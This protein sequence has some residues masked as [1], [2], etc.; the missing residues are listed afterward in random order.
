[1]MTALAADA[2]THEGV[3]AS[4]RW[5]A[6]GTSAHLLTTRG[7]ALWPARA[8]VEQELAAI[9]LAASR[10]RTDS[11]LSRL[12]AA[13]GGWVP[14]SPL[15]S[16][17]LR[18]ALD[19][20][21]WTGGMVD[22]TVGRSLLDIGYTQTYRLVPREGPAISVALRPA[23][24]WQNLELDETAG[25]ARLTDGILLD[26][27]ATAKGLA[28]DL[29]AAAAAAAC[30][31]GVLVNLGGDVSVA[32]EVPPGGWPVLVTDDSTT[33]PDDAAALTATGEGQTIALHA[34]GLATSGTRARRW[35]RGGSELHHIV[36]PRSGRPTDGPWR[37]VSVAAATCVMANAASTATMVL[38]QG[39][40]SW[41]QQ[42][43]LAARLVGTDGGVTTTQGW[44]R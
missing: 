38:G 25:C 7:E 2:A 16:Q 44:P 15:F 18:V 8:A 13:R 12:N 14:V 5:T 10:F 4:A 31:A 42:K 21:T 40:L 28:S 24:G 17:A 20:A 35:R 32:G 39:G 9:D 6:L 27:G 36:D 19:A 22:P 3:F 33:S 41:L 37:T 11:E 1:M 34:G 23:P 29:A 30:G 43:G 26:L